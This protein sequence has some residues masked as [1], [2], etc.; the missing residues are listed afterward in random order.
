LGSDPLAKLGL[1]TDADLIVHLPLRYEDETSVAPI[2]SLRDG[3]TAQIEATVRR[4]EIAY[5]PRR[6]LVVHVADDTGTLA[7]RFFNF[8]P[9]Q[10]KALAAGVTVRAFGEVRGG[11]L[12]AEMVHPRVRVLRRDEPLPTALTPVYPSTAGV[13]QFV[14]RRAIDAALARDGLADTLPEPIRARLRLLP[15]RDAVLA[16]HRPTPNAAIEPLLE[17]T[18]PAW[19]A[20]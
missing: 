16:L 7:L 20:R 6:Q 15:F 4:A 8:Y 17:R 3:D 18:H 1:R 19:R 2:A 14:L 10:Q 13:S 11:L 12:G 5:R 9:S